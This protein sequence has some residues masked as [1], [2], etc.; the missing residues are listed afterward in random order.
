VPAPTLDTVAAAAGLGDEI[1]CPY[2]V[3]AL[4]LRGGA[5]TLQHIGA[6]ARD[7]LNG[8]VLWAAVRPAP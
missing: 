4:V 5:D 2:A 3:D 6:D 7:A 8:K 1:I